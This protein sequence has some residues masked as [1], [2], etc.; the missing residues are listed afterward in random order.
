MNPENIM[1]SETGRYKRLHIARFHLCEMSRIST[2]TEAECR[3]VGARGFRKANE[4]PL[5]IG[6][7]FLLGVM[8]LF[9][10]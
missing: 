10:N 7:G 5:L 3:L 8:K 4:E 1:L 2:S 9:W 6:A